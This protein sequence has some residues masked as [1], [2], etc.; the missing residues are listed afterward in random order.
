MMGANGEH[1]SYP[2]QS[3]ELLQSS[4]KLH[5]IGGSAPGG[6]SSA[7]EELADLFKA[8]LAE[9]TILLDYCNELLITH[10]LFK[11]RSLEIV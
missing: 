7:P 11:E 8:L 6:S 1:F 3:S 5:V 2:P 10:F 4:F 9:Y